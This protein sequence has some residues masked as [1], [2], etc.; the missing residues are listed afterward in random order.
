MIKSIAFYG[1]PDEVRSLRPFIW[2]VLFGY[3]P[4]EKSKW[5]KILTTNRKIYES[6]VHE[7]IIT[8]NEE[9]L[10]LSPEFL[11]QCDWET[12]LLEKT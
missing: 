11:K 2:R 8:K 1:I 3:L 6:F 9:I 5:T 10:N 7:L 4:L 12:Y